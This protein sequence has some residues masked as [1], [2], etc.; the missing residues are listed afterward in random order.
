MKKM[1]AILCVAVLAASAVIGVTNVRSSNKIKDLNADLAS[2]QDAVAESQKNVD[3]LTEEVA[4]KATEIETLTAD[5]AKKEA[6]IE[7]LTADVADREAQIQTL[8]AD[9]ADKTAQIAALNTRVEANA[10]E[11]AALTEQATAAQAQIDALAAESAQ[12]NAQIDTLSADLSTAQQKLQVIIDTIVGPQ[13]AEK[14][15]AGAALPQ[16]GDVVNGFEVKEILEFPLVNAQVVLFEHQQTGAQ[17]TYVANEDTNRAFQLTFNTRPLDDTGLPH[18]FE[19]ATL[20]GSDKYP[21]TALWMNLVYQTYNTYMNAYTA[22]AM[23]C[24][25]IASLS[26][27]QLLKYADYYT[28]SCLHPSVLKDESIYRTEAWRYRMADMEDDLTIE[29]TVYTEMLGATTLDRKA[30]YNANRVTFPG[31]AIALDQ[32][33]DPD[34]IPDMTWEQLQDYHEKFY[35][36]ANCMVYLYGQFEDYTAFLELLDQAFAPYERTEFHY[37]DTAYT[38]ITEPVQLKVGYPMAEGTDPENQSAIYYYIVCPGMKGDV[39][40]EH[41]MDNLFSLLNQDS[42]LL[43]QNLKK[44]LPTGSF[45]FGREVAAPDDAIVFVASNVN[46]DDGE[47]FR[48]T[49][50]ASLREIAAAGFPQDMVDSAMATLQLSTKLAPE[51]GDPVGGVLQ[52]LAYSYAT[53]GNP[54]DYLDSLAAAEQLDEMNRQGLYQQAITDWLLDKET[55]TLVTTYPEPGQKEAHDEALAQLLAEIKANMTKEEKQAI[56]DASNAEPEDGDAA[57][58]VAQL[59]AVTVESLPEEIRKYDVD[60]VTGEDGI[61][62][63]DVTAGVDGVGT[64]L[65]YLDAQ[66][67]PQEDIHYMRLFTRLLGQLDTDAHTK[68]EL[69]V[70]SARYLYGKTIGV[71]VSGTAKDYHPYLI[72]QW[73]AMDDDLAAGY[74]LMEELVFHT[75]FTDAQKLLE[76]VQAEKASVRS[77]INGAPYNVA[78]FRGF[79]VDAPMWQ[80]YNYL[81]Y[82]DYY[83]F[84]ER[85][86]A[87]IAENPQE[88]TARLETVQSFFANSFGAISAFAGNENSIRANRALADAFLAGLDNTE[89][90]AARY[91]LPVPARNEAIIVDTN[92]QFNNIFASFDVLGMEDYDAG[93]NAISSLVTDTYLIPILRDQNGVYTPW[94]GEIQNRGMYLI[95]SRDPKVKETFD[96]YQSLPELI[97]NLDVD[98]ET[99]DGYILSNYAELAKGSGELT[100]A[101]DVISSTVSGIPQ[102]KV[103]AYMEQLKAVTPESVKAAAALYQKAWDHGVHSTAGSA[104][105]INANA[106]LYDVILNPFGAKDN[107]QVELSDIA[108]GDAYYEAVRFVFEN[109]LMEARAEDAFGVAEDATVGEWALAVYQLLG[110]AG[111]QEEAVEALASVG[112][113]APDSDPAAVMS[114][115]DL[116]GSC[117]ILCQLA[118]VENMDTTLPESKN[119]NASRGDMALILMRLNE[120]E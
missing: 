29:G 51:S 65:L 117:N 53:T 1:I 69:D 25:P 9:V 47:L 71:S 11:I 3:A 84:I 120:A 93:L 43:M 18:V 68:E 44:A 26:E 77:S 82:L 88:A 91:D 90:Q 83:A 97:A 119:E 39:E 81:N 111:S 66:A 78:M 115:T 107:S 118:Q 87:E 101:V 57:E 20:S 59:Q 102:E 85:L 13:E 116:I 16:V 36:P 56:I 34:A 89:R 38:P 94:N 50:M 52:S 92:I 22:D 30:L 45:G 58:L 109:G 4:V 6:Q 55:W 86:E 33:G 74:D 112:M 100:G 113:L 12:K 32:G 79:A 27:T 49:I 17:L 105:A 48:D 5:V 64:A 106:D 31:A 19:H 99:L 24:Y 76:R 96:V 15:E 41:V 37:A 114:R 10:A 95:T 67:L 61:R 42:S 8:T 2:M 35:H 73:T 60:D 14:A 98:Q 21:S 108:Q 75:Q 46:E 23:T 28:D 80:Y 103:L 7:T 104:A 70:L 40:Q 110:G 54:Y 62:R 72:L 63:I